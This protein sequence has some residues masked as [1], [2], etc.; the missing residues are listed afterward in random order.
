MSAILSCLRRRNFA[1]EGEKYIIAVIKDVQNNMHI[2]PGGA[3]KTTDIFNR[4]KII[5]NDNNKPI[6]AC[7]QIRKLPLQHYYIN[8]IN[9]PNMK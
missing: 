7:V 6:E 8:N 1:E 2:Q 4:G 5:K 3:Y 9:C